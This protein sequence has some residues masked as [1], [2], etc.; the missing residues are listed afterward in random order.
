[1]SHQKFLAS[2][3]LEHLI[4]LIKGA[5]EALRDELKGADE[6]LRDEL[7]EELRKEIEEALA[8]AGAGTDLV[9]DGVTI[10]IKGGKVSV[11][12]G[13]IGTDQIADA[14]VTRA[15]LSFDPTDGID[16]G[17]IGAAPAKHTHDASDVVSGVLAVVRGGT[18]V[19]SDD[20]AF[21]KYVAAHYPDN[22]ELLAYLGLS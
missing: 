5:D 13:G 22:D 11:K 19:T 14:S 2:E 4:A 17:S 12:T 20:A 1:M 3:G 15:K 6:A 10:E 7:S 16:A 9:G 21:Q 18:G 8:G